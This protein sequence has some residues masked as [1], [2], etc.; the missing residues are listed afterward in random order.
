VICGI[1][2][3]DS[4]GFEELYLR[5]CKAVYSL[6]STA[7]RRNIVRPFSGSKNNPSKK[8][9]VEWL[10]TNYM[11]LYLHSW[12][13]A[14]MAQWG[15]WWALRRSSYPGRSRNILYDMLICMNRWTRLE[16][17]LLSSVTCESPSFVDTPLCFSAV[18]FG[19]GIKNG[20]FPSL[21]ASSIHSHYNFLLFVWASFHFAVKSVETCKKLA[22]IHVEGVQSVCFVHV[23]VCVTVGLW[24]TLCSLSPYCYR[25]R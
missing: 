6:K 11:S 16:C 17:L 5:G 8:L 13:W 20:V 4:S 2:G 19:S 18:C 14:L 23:N 15:K 21:N 10:R 12:K 1:R 25:A 3:S 7:F 9:R 24:G 22:L